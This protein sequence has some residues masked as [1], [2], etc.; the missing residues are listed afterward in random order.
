MLDRI[1]PGLRDD[2]AKLFDGHTDAFRV[3]TFITS[4]SEHADSEDEYGR[5]SMWRAYGGRAG[6]ALVLNNA[7]FAAE[8]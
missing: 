5:L 3:G 6:V 4:L 7:A 8:T 2:L 1:Q